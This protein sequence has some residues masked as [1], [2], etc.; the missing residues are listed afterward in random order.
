M[1]INEVVKKLDEIASD[2][3]N[4]LS[5]EAKGTIRNEILFLRALQD[6]VLLPMIENVRK[7]AD[8]LKSLAKEQKELTSTILRVSDAAQK[9]QE[10]I[11][12]NGVTLQVTLLK[13]ITLTITR[14]I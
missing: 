7:S 5:D 13:L 12:N 14:I 4:E 9:A 6:T 10:A 1:D 8:N 11:Q 2:P 3:E